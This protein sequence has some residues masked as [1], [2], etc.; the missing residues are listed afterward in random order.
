MSRRKKSILFRLL[1]LA[2]LALTVFLVA[3]FVVQTDWFKNKVRAR[4]I[5]VAE[6]ASGGRVEIGSFNYNWHNLTVEVAPF[7]LHGKEPPSARPFFRADKIQ[8]GLKIISALEKKVD[9]RW[10]TV[11]K[12]QLYVT[13]APDGSTNVPTPKVPRQS[14]KNFAEELLDLKVGHIELRDGL[15]DYNSQL[16][17]LDV[18]CDQLRA[19][20]TYQAAGPRYV[21]EISSRQVRAVSP[22]LKGPVAFDL[23]TKLILEKNQFPVLQARM[24]TT[25]LKI[26]LDG[27][28]RDLSSPHAAFDV[29]AEASVKELNKLFGLPLE[30]RGKVSFQ[31]KGTVDASPFQYKLDG[32]LGA[33]DLA[34][35]QRDLVV[36][37]I[38][39][40]SRLQIN[41]GKI[42]L[43]DLQVSA[44]HGHFRG[45]AE[46]L[47][48]KK[49]SVQGTAKDLSLRELGQLG[50]RETGE[51]SGILS[52]SVSLEGQF[53]RG[54]LG[55]VVAQAKLDITPATGGVPVQ[56][57]V[58][59]HYDQRAG[60]VQLGNSELN[61]GTTHVGVSG[62]LGQTLQVQV[63][64]KNLDDFLPLFPLFGEAPPKQLPV[65]LH[66][67][68]AQFDGSVTGPLANP[69]VSGK[70]D[71]THFALDRRE[72]DRFTS[73]FDIEKS[74]ANLR[75]LSVEQ[76]KM[77]VEGQGRIGLHDWKLEDSST[78]SALLSVQGAD[79]QKLLA[80]TESDHPVPITGSLAAKLQVSGTFE[81]PLASGNV[82]LENVTAYDQHFDRVR[83]DIT[84]TAN[85]L[86]VANG[87]AR[88]GAARITVSGAYNHPAND[89]KDGS[90][91]FDVASSRL[92]LT[93]IKQVQD[94]RKGLAGEV[95]VQ[96]AGTA[97]VVKGE[98]SLASLN[99]HLL[100]RSAVVDGRPYGNLELTAAT[101]L[102][103]L[104]LDAKVDFKGIQLSGSGEWRME[105]DYPG[106][107]RIQIPKVT[108][109][110]LHEL[111]PGV[112]E[113]NDLPFEGFIQGEALISG[114]LNKPGDMKAN[115]T[116]SAVQLSAGPNAK[117]PAG[118]Q[119]QDLVLKNAQPVKFEGTLKSIDIRSAEFVA[120]DTTLS[121]TG[122]LTL[123]SKNPWDLTVKGNVNL[124]ILQIFNPNLLAAG[125]SVVNMAVRGALTE[126]Q[127]D[128]RLELHNASLFLRDLP[129]GVDQANGLILFDRNRATVQTLTAVTGGGQVTFETGSFV[130][131]RGQ[132]LVYRL[133]ATAQQVRYR[134]PDGISVTVNATLSLLGTSEK[135]VLSGNVEVERATFNPRTDVGSLLAS[136]AKPVSVPSTPNDYL[137]GI[138]FDVAVASSRNL[139]VQTSLT[140]NIQADANFRVRGTPDRPVVLGNISVSSGQIEFF[141]NK[142]TINRGD[143]NFYNASKI[144][145]IIDMDLETQVRGVVVDISF[146]GSLN[147]LN[148]SYR[149][150]PPL[151]TNDIIALLAVG[152]APV[153]AGGLAS[154]QTTGTNYVATGGNAL[155]GQAIAPASGRLQRFFGVSHI[156]IDPQL[157]GITSVPQARLTLEQ[158]VS[159]DITLTYITNLTRTDQQ[160]VRVEWDFSKKWSVVALRDENGAFGIDFQYR[161]RF[162]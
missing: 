98:F 160:I 51:L 101:K 146:S 29:S 85:A 104:T 122:R 82:D 36:R 30:S 129:N 105:G 15:A 62:T 45:S 92:S 103:M 115:V 64:S 69:R 44:L 43:P 28:V 96:A 6:T 5:S 113:R 67:G 49:L 95:D 74:G 107:A 138:Q 90:V 109:S 55:G 161:K 153:T 72:F 77:R 100:L 53:V 117:P 159:T 156:K 140:R 58:D 152:R 17:P 158:Q 78:V 88:N 25:D 73:T 37:N 125:T 24:A 108:F 162:K 38:A 31:G 2:G 59:I 57:A 141:G 155:L 14:N 99:G 120:K 61:L 126:P 52:G 56:G 50:A 131:F 102:P 123:D 93:Q 118:T 132:A 8:I 147:K 12:P 139:E 97:K 145:P 60:T 137:R 23:D 66:G 4:I 150:D 110:T 22:Q 13:V 3:I 68:L 9:I 142:Y 127:V 124:S 89:W 46:V 41:P 76:G 10:L 83:G 33:T 148:F 84:V 11:E 20:L 91:R 134:S 19:S 119:A 18:Q 112:H 26:E 106:Q 54:S 21:G 144:D 157:T 151:E 16:I 47:D 136:T 75:T 128:G 114:A 111:W 35:A 32:H 42:S 27:S 1:G 65:A 116:L 48:L 70:A 71:V 34:Y 149:S 94:F 121:A 130:G 133:Q 87:E 63:V 154:S 135:S 81:S 7:I 143:V 86:E 79:L 40:S 39:L 80:E